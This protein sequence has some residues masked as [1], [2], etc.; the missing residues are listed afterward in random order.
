[1][2]RPLLALASPLVLVTYLGCSSSVEPV[3]GGP[4]HAG[5][6][7][8][9][10]GTTTT[11]TTTT[12]C[13]PSAPVAECHADA[14]CDDGDPATVDSCQLKEGL[15]FPVGT[16]MHSA[17][18]G[19]PE[20]ASEAV[21]PTCSVGTAKVVY[22]PFSPLAAPDVPAACAGGFQATDAKAKGGVTYVL[23]ASAAAG[24]RAITLDLDLATYTAPDGVQITG[25]DAQ[26]RRYVLFDSCRLKT[27]TEGEEVY[28]DGKHRPSDEAIRQYRIEVR[29]GTKE[30]TFDFSRVVSPMYLRVLGLCDFDVTDPPSGDFKWFEAVD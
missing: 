10:A 30:L 13:V 23:A 5:A 3:T 1:M 29:K 8:S 14:D 9:G 16:C 12:V 7:A 15:E 17:C 6:G 26:C 28:T 25:I 24:S 21:D 2:R 27:A 18:D 19:G 20:C 11:T 22:P 4:S